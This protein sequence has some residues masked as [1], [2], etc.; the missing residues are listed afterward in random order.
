MDIIKSFQKNEVGVNINIKGTYEEPLFRASDIG[1]ILDIAK[2]R[3]TI[4]DF[5]ETEKVAHTV[6]TLG[7]NQEVT[8]LTEKGLYQV[9]FTSRKPIAKTFKN[10][11]CEVIKDIR[12]SGKYELEKQLEIKNREIE[13]EK[14]K[15]LNVTGKKIF[16]KTQ[17]EFVYVYKNNSIE[18]DTR[19]KIGRTE[20]ITQRESD[21]L[22]SNPDGKMMFEMP[23]IDSSLIEKSVHHIL[24]KYRII[25]NREWFNVDLGIIKKVVTDSVNLHD[26]NNYTPFIQKTNI[27]TETHVIPS[28]RIACIPEEIETINNPL[29]YNK[30]IE[31]CCEVDESYVCIKN[32]LYGMYKFWSRCNN[33]ETTENARVYFEKTFKIGKQYFEEYDKSTLAIY[34]GIRLKKIEYISSSPPNNFD[35]FMVENFIFGPIHRIDSKT[36][37]KAYEEYLG[38]KISGN[39]LFELKEYIGR[40]F[41][42]SMIHL[43][44]KGQL[45]GYWGLKLKNDVSNIGLKVGKA[46]RKEIIC[47]NIETLEVS[48]FDS[49]VEAATY[50]GVKAS[51]I[52]VDVKYK[53]IRNG[54]YLSRE[55]LTEIPSKP[56]EHSKGDRVSV[57]KFNSNNELVK[58]FKSLSEAADDIGINRTTFKQK[59]IF[60]K[61]EKDGFHW[62]IKNL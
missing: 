61:E 22:C 7:G 10:W 36:L 43:G 5:D 20:N 40:K 6:G 37:E 23:C 4:Q 12:L 11:V 62:S 30:F 2:I 27:L 55:K 35:K 51:T 15:Y 48:T 38:K 1:L 47:T 41:F 13:I 17:G 46:L 57:Y 49:L 25:S 59:Y 33:E 8:F 32:E 54:C 26:N 39:E 58:E 3:N 34:K 31:N 60:D 45:N 42:P 24:D 44:E 53:R 14:K 9:L 50:F 52:S 56:I 28:K 16:E 19:Y 29:D 18:N 21:F